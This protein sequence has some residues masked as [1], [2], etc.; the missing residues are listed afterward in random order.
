MQTS[1]VY[2]GTGDEANEENMKVMKE[3]VKRIVSEFSTKSTLLSS[4]TMYIFQWGIHPTPM[5]NDPDW[6]HNFY[7]V[8]FIDL[9]DHKTQDIEFK[10]KN[11][12]LISYQDTDNLGY[13]EVHADWWQALQKPSCKI[14][15]NPTLKKCI[16]TSLAACSYDGYGVKINKASIRVNQAKKPPNF[17]PSKISELIGL[18]YMLEVTL[19][20]KD[21]KIFDETWLVFCTFNLKFC[22]M[23]DKG[24][25]SEELADE[26]AIG[27]EDIEKLVIASREF[28][29]D[30]GK[31]FKEGDWVAENYFIENLSTKT[32]GTFEARPVITMKNMAENY[33]T[34]TLNAAKTKTGYE[35]SEAKA[36]DFVDLTPKSTIWVTGWQPFKKKSSSFIEEFSKVKEVAD[37]LYKKQPEL[38]K[39]PITKVEFRVVI[40][41]NSGVYSGCDYKLTFGSEKDGKTMEFIA[42]EFSDLHQGF[43]LIDPS[44]KDRFR[45][46]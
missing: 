34:V 8:R 28:L 5:K 19:R 20:G 2:A 24:Q 36:Y 43:K 25:K 15:E 31:M 44:V 3:D 37:F 16:E 27:P 33:E 26:K 40:R 30:E 7:N 41:P 22:V 11:N 29:I 32:K 39:I 21:S 6:G 1:L 14:D 23:K 17:D 35:F 10:L 45:L 46:K 42:W 4:G 9:R 13:S 12:K 18:D 38:K